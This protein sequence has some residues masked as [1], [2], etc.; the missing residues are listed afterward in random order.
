MSRNGSNYKVKFVLPTVVNVTQLRK[1]VEHFL[2]LNK[3]IY[4]RVGC[5]KDQSGL[6]PYSEFY[7]CHHFHPR[8]YGK[9]RSKGTGC[10]STITASIKC[11][12]SSLPLVHY[13]LI[14]INFVHNH[15]IQSRETLKFRKP[16]AM[17]EKI[18]KRLLEDGLSPARALRSFMIHLEFQPANLY[19]TSVSDRT[20]C[21]DYNWVHHFC[22]KLFKKNCET[23]NN[24][25]KITSLLM[26]IESL[27]QEHEQP[28]CLCQTLENDNVIICLVTPLMRRGLMSNAAAEIVFIETVGSTDRFKLKVYLLF[29]EYDITRIPIGILIVS[30]DKQAVI[31][32]AFKL[33]LCLCDNS[34]FGGRGRDGPIVIMSDQLKTELKVLKSVFPKCTLLFCT[35]HLLRGVYKWL[36]NS[37]YHINK[38]DLSLLYSLIRKLIYS[39]NEEELGNNFSAFIASYTNNP[40]LISYVK[41]LYDKKNKWALCYRTVF[42]RRDADRNSLAEREIQMLVEKIVKHIKLK[43]PATLIKYFF[44]DFDDFYKKKLINKC[45]DVDNV[46]LVDEFIDNID[47]KN[48]ISGSFFDSDYLHYVFNKSK[49]TK[50]ILNTD[51][52][53]CTCYIGVTGN[54]C[55]HQHILTI[56]QNNEPALHYPIIVEPNM[57]LYYIATGSTEISQS[58]FDSVQTFCAPEIDTQYAMEVV[59]RNGNESDSYSDEIEHSLG[60]HV[61]EEILIEIKEEIDVRDEI[62]IME[63]LEGQELLNRLRNHFHLFVS[64]LRENE[65]Y[66]RNAALTMHKE[67][68]KL[69]DSSAAVRLVALNS[70][71]CPS[72]RANEYFDDRDRNRQS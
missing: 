48:Y 10:K 4:T 28:V 49:K 37:K 7:R 51:V 65:S 47:V 41:Q 72:I 33:F 44:H 24:S 54:Y 53:L 23:V 70:F 2:E 34:S 1:W 52:G 18:F 15:P 40:L 19:L 8:K 46:F 30:L 3:C 21:P 58:F 56:N 22:S 27:N 67:L 55:K 16:S 68:K 5:K 31:E 69:F 45:V 50:Y 38:D 20:K 9:K 39:K 26:Y 64:K 57:D 62:P 66:Y 42:L 61:V 29:T 32:Q 25:G 63:Q 59:L 36:L 35:F 6:T 71:Q 60:N 43:S 13:A 12:F 11:D 14:C 17:V